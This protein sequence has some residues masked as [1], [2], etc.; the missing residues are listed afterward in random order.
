M[1]HHMQSAAAPTAKLGS[2]S[3]LLQHRLIVSAHPRSMM[4]GTGKHALVPCAAQE[5][6]AGPPF[7]KS[8]RSAL[9]QRVGGLAAD[10]AAA[11][12]MTTKVQ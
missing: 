7:S 11:A 9:K 8:I 12:F 1:L 2:P 3:P 10:R 5:K 6:S 4:N